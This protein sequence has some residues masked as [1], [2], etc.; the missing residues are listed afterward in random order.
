MEVVLLPPFMLAVAVVEVVVE[1][2]EEEEEEEEEEDMWAR[3]LERRDCCLR[4]WSQA[5]G[6]RNT[7]RSTR[8]MIHCTHPDICFVPVEKSV[9][10]LHWLVVNGGLVERR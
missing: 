3:S 7:S 10:W 8:M 9:W 6:A 5:R 4:T 1:K 2:E